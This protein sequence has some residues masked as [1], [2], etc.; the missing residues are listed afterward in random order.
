MN[1]RNEIMQQNLEN[2]N[3]WKYITSFILFL[4]REHKKEL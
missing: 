2:S 4:L 3:P 1:K